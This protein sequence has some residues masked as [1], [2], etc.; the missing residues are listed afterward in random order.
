M[1][2]RDKYVPISRHHDV[3]AQFWL[4]RMEP[5]R[6]RFGVFLLLPYLRNDKLEQQR[7]T[8][9]LALPKQHVHHK[10]WVVSQTR[11]I[12]RDAAAAR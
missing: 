1:M 8:G 12:L 11:C 5:H 10:E 4:L 2:T 3:Q 6:R 7:S 9:S